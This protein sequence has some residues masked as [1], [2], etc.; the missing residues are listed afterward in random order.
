MEP[1]PAAPDKTPVAVKALT[2]VENID[3]VF[4]NE[5]ISLDPEKTF[6]EGLVESSELPE[7]EIDVS[8]SAVPE[9]KYLKKENDSRKGVI[10]FFEDVEEIG[11]DAK[12]VAKRQTR[13]YK[14]FLKFQKYTHVSHFVKT[15]EIG[16]YTYEKQYWNLYLFNRVCFTIRQIFSPFCSSPFGTDGTCPMFEAETLFKPQ[17]CVAYVGRSRYLTEI[18]FKKFSK[19]MSVIHAD[20]FEE[21]LIGEIDP[22]E[23]MLDCGTFLRKGASPVVAP[24]E[25][26]K[27]NEIPET[28]IDRHEWPA[29][30]APQSQQQ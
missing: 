22:E 11:F 7:P 1:T 19:V 25:E 9:K 20:I 6:E 21:P 17:K 18:N 12:E 4:L 27:A 23:T 5:E 29:D 14:F 10:N 8:S 24:K 30:V 3:I 28:V 16:S 2:I 26:S 13:E 15:D